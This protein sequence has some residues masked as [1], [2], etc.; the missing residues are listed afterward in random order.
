MT[1]HVL[2]PCTH[3]PAHGVPFDGMRAGVAIG[4]LNRAGAPPL[5]IDCRRLR[6][7]ALPLQTIDRLAPTRG[8][9]RAEVGR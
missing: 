3:H 1:P 5:V 8:P 2:I 7:Q 6:P 9:D 4:A